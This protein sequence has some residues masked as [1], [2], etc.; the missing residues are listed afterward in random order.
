M[1]KGSVSTR[2]SRAAVL[3]TILEG[4]Q[5]GVVEEL[6]FEKA[7]APYGRKGEKAT[8]S[9]AQSPWQEAITIVAELRPEAIQLLAA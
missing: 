4:F 7:T 2:G 5:K 9:T 8:Y 1:I 6:G 3:S